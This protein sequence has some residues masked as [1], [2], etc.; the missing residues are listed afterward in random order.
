MEI[1]IEFEAASI[2][3][4]DYIETPTKSLG[5]SCLVGVRLGVERNFQS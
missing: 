1:Y 5:R 4:Q 3:V 2:K